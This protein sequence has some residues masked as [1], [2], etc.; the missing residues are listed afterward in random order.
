MPPDPSKKTSPALRGAPFV[1]GAPGATKAPTPAL[2]DRA[3]ERENSAK[4]PRNSN[5]VEPARPS[6]ARRLASTG[7]YTIDAFFE[8]AGI[9]P[10]SEGNTYNSTTYNF[11][12][13]TNQSQK[14]I[15]QYAE[16]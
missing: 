6:S 7:P 11:N 14:K 15:S 4:R 3:P 5:D 1:V 12:K 16:S 9:T 13:V 2:T 10:D 8:T